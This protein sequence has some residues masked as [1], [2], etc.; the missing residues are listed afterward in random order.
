MDVQTLLDDLNIP[1]VLGGEHRH[2]REGWLGADCVWCG[3]T[4]KFHLGI[5]VN[6]PKVCVCWQCGRHSLVEFFHLA[7]DI[8][9][10]KAYDLVDVLNKYIS[11][12]DEPKEETD[13]ETKIPPNLGPIKGPYTK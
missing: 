10:Q 12:I 2:A 13:R 7:A 8:P 5:P 11:D 9:W 3:T 4:G 6:N 1:F